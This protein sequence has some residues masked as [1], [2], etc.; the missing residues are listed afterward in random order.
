[1]LNTNRRSILYDLFEV[2]FIVS[3][4]SLIC[5]TS[6]D[7]GKLSVR[8]LTLICKLARFPKSFC[9]SVNFHSTFFSCFFP[10]V[11]M[12]IFPLR[13]PSLTFL[14]LVFGTLFNFV[15]DSSTRST[16]TKLP[17]ISSCFY[18]FRTHFV[19]FT[20]WDVVFKPNKIRLLKK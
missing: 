19:T 3:V 5:F 17:F 16:S 20:L 13:F 1:M 11:T 10:F 2:S 4:S 9:S 12:F 14:I 15:F 6:G 8:D 18:K 7:V